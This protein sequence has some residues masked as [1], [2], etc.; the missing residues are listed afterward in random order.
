MPQKLKSNHYIAATLLACGY[1]HAE[2]AVATGFTAMYISILASSPLF[3]AEVQRLRVQVQSQLVLDASAKLQAEAMNNINTLLT[4]RDD[5]NLSPVIRSS[6]ARDMLD[7]LTATAKAKRVATQEPQA[8]QFTDAQIEQ[9]MS[10]LA[11][12]PAAREAYNRAA[13][14]DA[15]AL[16]S[17]EAAVEPET[18]VAPEAPASEGIADASN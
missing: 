2:V 11:D 15:T 3:A 12:D 14:A 10:A 13:Y 6:V 18:L 7:R 17:V 8:V 1:S 16:L 4:I 9:L 5:P